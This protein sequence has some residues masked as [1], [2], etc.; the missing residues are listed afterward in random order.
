VIVIIIGLIMGFFWVNELVNS[1]SKIGNIVSKSPISAPSTSLPDIL[2]TTSPTTEPSVA[3]QN[4]DLKTYVNKK[5]N[6]TINYPA[7]WSAR[8]YVSGVALS[9]KNKLMQDG[10]LKVEFLE[11]GSDYCKIPF[12]DYVK[13]A[14]PSEIQNYES[15]NTINDGSTDDGVQIYQVTWNYADSQ[16][17]GRISLPITYFETKPELCGDIEAFLNDNNYSDIYNQIISTFKFYAVK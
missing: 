15:V 7:D 11:R 17:I 10:A 6:F 14:G 2:Q 12:E 4:T 5:Y 9:P 3:S 8:D 1:F 13:I 16:G